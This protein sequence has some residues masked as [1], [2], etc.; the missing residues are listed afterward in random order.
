M[1]IAA[2]VGCVVSVEVGLLVGVLVAGSSLPQPVS[3][4]TAM[5]R[6]STKVSHR[7]PLVNVCIATAIRSLDMVGFED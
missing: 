7:D 6:H 5:D 2:A 3:R 1:D 4:T